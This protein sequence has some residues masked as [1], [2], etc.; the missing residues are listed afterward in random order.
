MERKAKP[1]DSV[2]DRDDPTGK[3]ELSESHKSK[4]ENEAR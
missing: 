4:H 1:C 2:T 3:K